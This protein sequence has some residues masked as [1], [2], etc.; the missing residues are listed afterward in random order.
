MVRPNGWEI[1]VMRSKE[2]LFCPSKLLCS[3][4][5][6]K[7]STQYK[8]IEL[9]ADKRTESLK[10]VTSAVRRTIRNKYH[11]YSNYKWVKL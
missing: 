6:K 2:I 1:W 5:S 11:Q 7:A 10:E 9:G 4:L 8:R 3:I